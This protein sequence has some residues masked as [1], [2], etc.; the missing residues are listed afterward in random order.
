MKTQ[1]LML[2]GR[3]NSS[4]KQVFSFTNTAIKAQPE[5][6]RKLIYAL[7]LFLF[8][9]AQTMV[10]A[11]DAW[12]WMKG[13]NTPNNYGVYGTQY[14]PPTV[15]NPGSRSESVSWTDAAGNQ[16]LFGGTGFSISSNGYMNDLWKFDISTN[17]WTFVKGDLTINGYGVYGTKGTPAP[18]N[19]PGARYGSNSW[20]DASGNLWL[21]GGIGNSG[22][23]FGHLNDLWKFSPSTNNWTWVNGDNAINQ[24]GVYGTKGLHA[25]SNKPGS[26]GHGISW[27]DAS[28]VLWMF[29]GNGF[30]TTPTQNHLNDLWNY[31]PIANEWTW[32]S[33]GNTTASFGVYYSLGTP[34][35]LNMPGARYESVSWLDGSGKL[36]L[37]GGGGYAESGTAGY[38]NDLWNYNPATGLWTWVKGDKTTYQN[39]S[40]GS[41]RIESP[42]NK[43]GTRMRSTAWVDAS[44][45]FWLYGGYGNPA[46]GTYGSLND[47]WKFKTSTNNWIWMKG[48]NAI[49]QYTV[50]GSLG[51]SATS[52]RPG[53]RDGS[54]SWTDA[55]GNLWMFGGNG[56]GTSSVGLLN[57]LWKFDLTTNNWTWMHGSNLLN[58]YT[59]NNPIAPLSPANKPGA[60]AAGVTW[61]DD[62]GKLWLFGGTGF[63][64]SPSS[65]ML[66]DLWFFD[67]VSNNWAWVKGDNGNNNVGIYGTKGVSAATNKP[68]SRYYLTGEKDKYGNMWMFGG[69]GFC[70]SSSGYLNDLWKY[71]SISNE[72]TWVSGDNAIN[73]PGVWGIKGVPN[74]SNKPSSRY[75]SMIWTDTV[76]NIWVFGGYGYGL[77][78]YGYLND[79]WKYDPITNIWTWMNGTN[80]VNIPGI[81]GSRGVPNVLNTPG[82]RNS[83]TVW[84]DKKGDLWL[85]GGDGFSAGP[86]GQL[87][88]LWKYQVASNTWTWVNGPNTSNGYG[89]YG[90]LNTFSPANQPGTRYSAKGMV[91]NDGNLLLFSGYGRGVSGSTNQLNDLWKYDPVKNEWAWIK[92]DQSTGNYGIY[93]SQGVSLGSNKPGSRFYA[94]SWKD[95]NGDFWAYGGS[96]YAS[97]SAGMLND[98]WKYESD[99]KITINS[100]TGPTHICINETAQTTLSMNISVTA[101]GYYK[102]QVY[103]FAEIGN[104]GSNLV[105]DGP[106]V[107]INAGNSGTISET[108][109]KWYLTNNGTPSYQGKRYY[110]YATFAADPIAHHTSGSD[111]FIDFKA[112][113]NAAADQ[114]IC[115][116]SNVSLSGTIGG[117]ATT[118]SWTSSGTGI[119]NNSSLLNATYTPSP[120]DIISGSVVLTLTTNDPIGPC[121]AVSDQMTV[122]INTA[123]LNAGV[124]QNVVADAGFATL[125]ASYSGLGITSATW[126]SSGTGTFSDN[127]SRTS[128]YTFSPADIAAGSVTLTFTTN[129]PAGPCAAAVDQVVIHIYSGILIN[130]QTGDRQICIND[131][132]L[133]FI[134]FNINAPL[135]GD[136]RINVYEFGTLGA[137]GANLCYIGNITHIS[138]GNSGNVSINYDRWYFTNF[139][140]P[141]YQNKHYYVYVVD[142]ANPTTVYTQGADL[143]ILPSISGTISGTTSVC[144]NSTEPNVIF[145]GSNGTAPYTFTYTI[146]SGNV[147]SVTTTSGN[148]VSVAAPTTAE[149]TFVYDLLSVQDAALANCG[150]APTGSATITVNPV[151]DMSVSTTSTLID[152][153]GSNGGQLLCHGKVLFTNA[154]S[155]SSGSIVNY[156]WNFGDGSPVVNTSDND[157]L[158]HEFP[159]NNFINWFDPAFP[160]TTYNILVT[161]TSDQGCTATASISRDIK[162]GPDAVIGLSD[163]ETQNLPGNSFQFGNYSQNRHPSFIISS[164]WTM[165]DGSTSTNTTPV[166]KIYSSPGSYRVHLVTYTN[167][168]CTDTAYLDVTVLQT[169][170]S[171][172]IYTPNSCGNRNVSFTNTS[173]L[174]TSYSWNFGDGSALVS[175]ENPTHLYSVDGSYTVTLTINGILSSSQTINIATTPIVGS[176]SS[177]LNSCDNSYTFSNV[178]SGLNLTYLW[179]FSGGTG[180]TSTSNFATRTYAS[181]ASTSVDLTVTSDGRCSAAAANLSFTPIVGTGGGITAGF[182][183]TLISGPCGKRIQF[184]NTT[185]GS[186]LTYWWNFGDGN[187]SSQTNPIKG[188]SSQGSFTVTLTASNGTCSNTASAVVNIVDLFNGPFA[189][190]TVN[191]T[192]QYLAGNRFNFFNTTQ[193]IGFGW[194]TNYTWDFG[195]G[196]SS[197]NTFI[198]DKTYSAAGVYLVTL[199]A[200][201]STGC[202]DIYQ[203]T[204]VVLPSANASFTFS[205]NNCSNRSVN[206]T[207][208]STLASTYS[209]DFGDGSPLVTTANPTHLYSADGYYHVTLTINGSVS[210]SHDIVVSTTPVAAFSYALGTCGNNY[211]FT[212]TSTGSNLSY[213]W[214][215]G[216]GSTSTLTNP[217]HGYSTSQSRTVTLTTTAANVC[218]SVSSQTFVTVIGGGGPIASFTSAFVNTSS[219]NTGINFTSTSSGAISY[220]WSY[221]DGSVSSVSSSPT[222]F[223]SYQAT[224][225]YQATLTIYGAGGCSNTSE[226]TSVV[227]SSVGFAG[228]ITGFTTLNS[229]QC[230]LG[231]KFDFFNTTWINGWGW[232]PFYTWDFGDG[233]PVFTNTHI[234]A[235]TFAAP[236]IYPVTLSATTNTGC[237][238]TFTLNVTVVAASLCGQNM[239]SLPDNNNYN[240]NLENNPSEHSNTTGLNR[241]DMSMNLNLY[242]NPND[243]TF[244]LTMKDIN[245]KSGKVMIVDMLGR[246][247]LNE[248]IQLKGK[249][250]IE[251][252]DLDLSPGKY[253]LILVT[254]NNLQARKSFAIFK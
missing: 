229:T 113:T 90:T 106:S 219:C 175:T 52:N 198:Y 8:T 149:G 40:Y 29:G 211:L 103:E 46:F 177:N 235:K 243:G 109:D 45:D 71:N 19:K 137:Q 179:T 3:E 126:S 21:F 246:E 234:Y 77:S 182:T 215:F 131:F 223:H 157:I 253:Y 214:D 38:L 18:A 100:Q 78:G 102:I 249:S 49:T 37:F 41:I 34:S 1:E 85:F 86:I 121:G 51:V 35:A 209:W 30:A 112:V 95:N 185:Q 150:A 127:T 144:K 193:H 83:A 195:D 208:T 63:P 197:T 72:W 39:G 254:D 11:Q 203:E 65:G 66:N 251:F 145:T 158:K 101:S 5:K 74:P 64:G 2:T 27:I 136:Y 242:P 42:T 213:A 226:A 48:D 174:A 118:A 181:A 75:N 6:L 61:T 119:F 15:N 69:N 239:T 53:G 154:S 110:V 180:P 188:Y 155:I 140:N 16:W 148:S 134:T 4:L 207:S 104:P 161:A 152:P 96:G 252:N 81:Y 62:N 108:Y 165:G 76:G 187:T 183:S 115:S 238:Q 225:T 227:V 224:G 73:Q 147:L 232:V 7:L 50:Y 36:W 171:S 111:I 32:M 10:I 56:L 233:S 247:L 146:N 68:G 189:G 167:T 192:P 160:N 13:D 184:T 94:H 47:L 169:P 26:R 9:C 54:L 20:T 12:T 25:I 164:F 173:A 67:P 201:S 205:P 190:F 124:D 84:T 123:T 151:P 43:P 117:A 186:G 178:S 163:P 202:T 114:T 60:R 58:Q 82:A 138:E 79:L 220:V 93:G 217:T 59:I 139:G 172:F 17:V 92:G 194:I 22:S 240:N 216:D 122:T 80:S 143:V 230:V 23:S 107:L 98:L 212:N 129:D 99:F 204:V 237:T 116:G 168:G 156:A 135:T 130:S 141:S 132:S 236:G 222:S 231:N 248:Q 91:D 125:S 206:F 70:S 133:G 176:I 24:T 88:D 250:E 128:D 245:A 221:G 200:L 87:N 153:L 170:M 28:G 44:G 120:L 241:E 210:T 162:N 199:T 97:A 105:F 196:T 33:G 55:A 244:K 191:S 14:N 57:D 228:P 89:V 142:A 218:S 166:P 159:V 31:N